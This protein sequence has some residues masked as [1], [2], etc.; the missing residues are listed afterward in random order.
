[1][2]LRCFLGKKRKVV[3]KSDRVWNYTYVLGFTYVG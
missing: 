3:R 2:L 1:M